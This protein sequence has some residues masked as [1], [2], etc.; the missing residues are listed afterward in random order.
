MSDLT[1]EHVV[2]QAAAC[3][4]AGQRHSMKA[5]RARARTHTGS[6]IED[7]IGV[8]QSTGLLPDFGTRGQVMRLKTNIDFGC[9]ISASLI[10]HLF[11]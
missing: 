4:Q 5:S 7:D 8:Y 6:E 9:V 1:S 3:R 2:Q 10:K 11:H